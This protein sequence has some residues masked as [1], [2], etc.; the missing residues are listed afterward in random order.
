MKDY[1]Y[2]QAPANVNANILKPTVEYRKEVTKVIFSLTL[3]FAVYIILILLSVGLALSLAY[4]GL[5]LILFKVM[6]I[7]IMTG[8]GLA[9]IAL[10]VFYFLIKFIFS[11]KKI[12]RSHLHEI[13]AEEFPGLFTF[14]GRLS[15]ETKAPKPKKIYLSSDVNASVFYDS[16]F[17]S[18]FFP[19]KKNL[20]IGLGFVNSVN[21]S[22][23]KAVIAHEFGHFSQHS[24][25]LGSYVYNVNKVIHNLLYDN[26]GY[27]AAIEEWAGINGYFTV[28]AILTMKIVQAIQWIL[29]KVY[30][31]VNKSNL[32]LSRQ[33][34]HHAD[35]VAAFVCGPDPL[36]TALKRLELADSFY[37]LLM[38][39]YND[40]IPENIRPDNMFTQHLEIMQQYAEHNQLAMEDSL[41]VPDSIMPSHSHARR[42]VVKDQWASHPGTGE[43]QNYL[44]SLHI[45]RT[46]VVHESPWILFGDR[47]KIQRTIT[48]KLFEKIAF[49]G[50]V[51]ELTLS[52]FRERLRKEM[53]IAPLPKEYKGF[54]NNRRITTINPEDMSASTDTTYSSIQGLFIPVNCILPAELDQ[55]NNDIFLLNSILSGQVEAESFEFDGRK[56]KTN[57]IPGIIKMLEEEKTTILQKIASLDKEVLKLV[58]QNCPPE[59]KKT[60][61]DLYRRY[62][63]VCEESDRNLAV[64]HE[65]RE[66]LAPA[67]QE[68]LTFD[69]AKNIVSE[70][71]SVEKKIL[72][73]INPLMDEARR[74]E[75]ADSRQL[76]QLEHY[77]SRDWEYFNQSGFK[78][79]ELQLLNEALNNFISILFMR[80]SAAKRELLVKQLEILAMN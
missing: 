44:E 69:A 45:P 58:M 39:K 41:P 49:P 7:T 51:Q 42:I 22:E 29:K 25:R 21:L 54:Y 50:K 4:I 28:F 31:V 38:D 20:M 79:E 59:E 47:E 23:F 36:I 3:F 2:P 15:E 10:M 17:L 34:E 14:V 32:S 74:N 55:V 46:E 80:E 19:V 33:M 6:A 73:E 71:K 65:L 78:N 30:I 5:K 40:W 64:Y 68:K 75:W 26:E 67:Y 12:D 8:I 70:V 11:V 60:V 77:L 66:K 56:C 18:M 9:G 57:D 16:S 63:D 76:E 43:R 53:K 37:N 72:P 24:M 48:G 52:A 13:T 62:F 27:S 35:T 61:W 1:C